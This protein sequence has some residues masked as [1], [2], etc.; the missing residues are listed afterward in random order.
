MLIIALN[1][2]KGIIV[3]NFLKG[4]IMDNASVRTAIMM[5]FKTIFAKN[6]KIFG[7]ILI[8]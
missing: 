5:I 8:N 2:M 4:I 6:A 1:V 3:K 7:L